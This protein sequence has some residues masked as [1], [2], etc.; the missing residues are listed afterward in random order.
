[1][2]IAPCPRATRV[3][4]Y[5]VAV[6]GR[7]YNDDAWSGGQGFLPRGWLKHRSMSKRCC[8]RYNFMDARCGGNEN[9]FYCGFRVVV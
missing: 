8:V 7:M 6:S 9:Q 3:F 2:L 1:M 5:V 4:G